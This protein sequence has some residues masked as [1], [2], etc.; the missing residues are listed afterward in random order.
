[1]KTRIYLVRHAQAR[2]NV[3]MTFQGHTDS[4]L[5]D[6]GR[7]QLTF[8]QQRFAKVPID[9]VYASPL[10][11]AMLTAQAIA[12]PHGLPVQPDPGLIEIDG[13]EMEGQAWAALPERYPEQI[14]NWYHCPEKFDPP[15]GES[16]QHVY[17]RAIA[18]VERIARANPGRQ[19]AAAT[20]GGFLRCYLCYLRY[21]DIS[22][23]RQMHL[24]ENTGVNVVEFDEAFRPVLID[25]ND[26]SHLPE[27]LTNARIARQ[28]FEGTGGAAR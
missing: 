25:E 3:E 14:D 17:A 12:A 16:M 10:E 24:I 13:G 7:E 27:R 22:G 23:L 11:R 2:G 8:L 19:V 21:A 4:G 9:A 15:K 28:M 20:H 26:Y 5:T 1:M 6:A 18:A